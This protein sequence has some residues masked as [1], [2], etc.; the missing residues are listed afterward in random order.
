MLKLFGWVKHSAT[1]AP[2]IHGTVQ[3]PVV[4]P[5]DDDTPHLESLGKRTGRDQ[6]DETT[7]HDVVTMSPFQHDGDNGCRNLVTVAPRFFGTAKEKVLE[8]DRISRHE[9]GVDH[10]Q[11][12]SLSHAGMEMDLLRLAVGH[13]VVQ[14][15][16]EGQRVVFSHGLVGG[17]P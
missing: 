14:F 13:D 4:V 6:V 15:V 2:K 17:H 16:K 9:I 3:D 1:Q 7:V 12:Q 11:M 5:S 8:R 10:L